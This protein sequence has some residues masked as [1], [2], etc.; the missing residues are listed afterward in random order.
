ME[1]MSTQLSEQDG[2]QSNIEDTLTT[3]IDN[4]AE[5]LKKQVE[6][7]RE[8][9]KVKVEEEKQ[10]ITVLKEYKAKYTEFQQATK[11]SK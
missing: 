9:T 4:Q 6:A 2:K 10:L 3:Q 1:M 11:S 7:Y 8:Q 5:E